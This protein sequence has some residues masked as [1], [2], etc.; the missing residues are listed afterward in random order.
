MQALMFIYLLAHLLAQLFI[1][2]PGFS[3]HMFK[4]RWLMSLVIWCL[5]Y[6]LFVCVCVLT[7][8]FVCYL[9]IY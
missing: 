2:F 9:L 4:V 7:R 8:F 5:L 1:Y 3:R 6:L